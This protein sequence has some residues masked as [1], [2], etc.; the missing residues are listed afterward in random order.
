LTS[1]SLL[2]SQPEKAA[3]VRGCLFQARTLPNRSNSFAPF[4]VDKSSYPLL[5]CF[6]PHPMR[7]SSN[8]LLLI[9]FMMFNSLTRAF[10]SSGAASFRYSAARSL[11]SSNGPP[12]TSIVDICQEKIQQALGAQSVKVTGKCNFYNY[13][14]RRKQGQ[15]V[16]PCLSNVSPKWPNTYK[17]VP[18]MILTDLIFLLKWYLMHLKARDLSSGSSWCTRLFGRNSKDLS[19]KN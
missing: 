15:Y 10:R 13:S 12:D 17:K 1:S 18:M 11:A 19:S 6:L 3:A 7:Q 9:I 5:L 2:K 14:C 4:F 8:L 16:C